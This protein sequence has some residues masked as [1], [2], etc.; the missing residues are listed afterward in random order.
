MRVLII[1]D[2]SLVRLATRMLVQEIFG[3]TTIDEAAQLSQALQYAAAYRYDLIM[4][5]PGLPDIDCR[6][7]AIAQLAAVCTGTP[8]VVLSGSDHPGA[9]AE[10]L[11]AGASAFFSKAMSLQ[12]HRDALTVLAGMQGG[13][14]TRSAP[15]Q[16]GHIAH[17]PEALGRRE[18]DRQASAADD[19][20]ERYENF[21]PR[22]RDILPLL[23][24]GRPNKE[25][26]GALGLTES[27]VKQHVRSI[28]RRIGVR[29]RT[30]AAIAVRALGAGLGAGAD[31][32]DRQ[33]SS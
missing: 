21:S 3:T 10:A 2:H 33:P 15:C 9:M 27:T 4:M 29:N 22:E 24:L 11:D 5:D 20:A 32:V 26:A 16:I 25:I 12:E 19:T 13:R 1:E 23:S 18:D 31:A 7:A 17:Q 28:M 14:D 8:L 30:E 6:R